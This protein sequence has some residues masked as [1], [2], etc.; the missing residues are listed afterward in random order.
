MCCGIKDI[1][2]SNFLVIWIIKG[3]KGVLFEEF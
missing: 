3:V 1:K 2:K